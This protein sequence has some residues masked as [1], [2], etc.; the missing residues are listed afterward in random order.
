MLETE[1]NQTL[2]LTQGETNR[3]VEPNRSE[4][5][6]H[7]YGQLIFLPRNQVNSEEDGGFW[8]CFCF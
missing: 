4:V 3:S 8:F 7:V 2:S 5:H 1:E 6:P